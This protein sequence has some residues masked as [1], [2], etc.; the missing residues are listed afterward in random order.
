MS[1]YLQVRKRSLLFSTLKLIFKPKKIK[2][3][4]GISSKSYITN[5]HVGS[6]YSET[7]NFVSGDCKSFLTFVLFLR[8][9]KKLVLKANTGG[10]I[11]CSNTDNFLDCTVRDLLVNRFVFF[12]WIVF[13]LLKLIF[14]SKVFQMQ[15]DSLVR[16]KELQWLSVTT[17]VS[18][19]MLPLQL[20]S[21]M[22]DIVEALLVRLVKKF[23]SSGAS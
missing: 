14:H 7:N 16:Y 8:K 4:K 11:G 1:E 3:K 6:C 10:L 23:S 17:L 15:E 13:S 21:V 5:V 2:K 18:S 12:F 9:A 19:T 22:E 20:L